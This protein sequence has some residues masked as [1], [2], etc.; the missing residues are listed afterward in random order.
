MACSA[1]APSSARCWTSTGAGPGG[2]SRRPG[3]SGCRSSARPSPGRTS[4]CC[5]TSRRSSSTSS[6]T[7]WST[8]H[9][10][11]YRD[12]LGFGSH[13][14]DALVEGVVSLLTEIVWSG[15]PSGPGGARRGRGRVR[16]RAAAAGGRVP[17]PAQHGRYAS[18][19]EV[20]RLVHV[21]GDVRN[22]Y[23]AFFLGDV[24]KITG[25]ISVAVMGSPR[26]PLP[27]GE[28]A[29]LVTRLNAVP[30]ASGGGSGSACSPTRR[31]RRSSGC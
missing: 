3:R 5:G 24:E 8:R 23:A 4:S 29:A 16:Q 14:Y 15:V 10:Q 30:A 7:C 31:R 22:L 28:V 6:C 25:P 18:M 2:R 20:M 26:A 12:L 19:A 13:A 1:M 11:R 9:Y 21:V 27:A 17:H